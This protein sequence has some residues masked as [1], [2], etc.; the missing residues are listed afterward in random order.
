MILAFFGFEQKE[1][2]DVDALVNDATT[3][4]TDMEAAKK[5]F[6]DLARQNVMKAAM[7]AAPYTGDKAELESAVEA[8]VA[9]GVAE[10]DL[11]DAQNKLNAMLSFHKMLSTATEDLVEAAKGDALAIE[12]AAL[13]ET[14]AK[15]HD[16]RKN[17]EVGV[18]ADRN[19]ASGQALGEEIAKADKVHTL[20][21]SRRMY[22]LSPKRRLAD[23]SMPGLGTEGV[24]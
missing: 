22:V 18:A 7:K 8:A 4:L 16:A 20:F 5:K 9:A 11:A 17:A 15:T 13:E 6:K 12:V 24:L 19:Y 10:K 3:V 21:Y 1:E 14:I 2:D 23:P